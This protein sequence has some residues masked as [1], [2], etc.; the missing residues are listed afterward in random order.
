[1]TL[2]AARPDVR[3]VVL[4]DGPDAAALREQA[5]RLGVAPYLSFSG[6]VPHE[7]VSD[8]LAASDVV[9]LPSLREGNPNAVNEALASGRPVVAS[10]VGSLPDL[11]SA[12]RG[13]LVTPGVPSE[14]AW[15]LLSALERSWDP[16]TIA[17][18]PGRLTAWSAVA[19]RYLE[20]F[21]GCVGKRTALAMPEPG[22]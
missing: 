3:I 21:Q 18:A 16:S 6:T 9:C 19:D 4:G 2:A 12:D 10:R 5:E 15:G 8:W 1:M 14:L 11:V 13:L 17:A 20:L 22:G 7:R